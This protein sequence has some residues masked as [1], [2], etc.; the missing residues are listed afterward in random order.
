MADN[1][2]DIDISLDDIMGDTT[3]FPTPDKSNNP[4]NKGGQDNNDP[5]PDDDNNDDSKF[6]DINKDSPEVKTKDLFV[7][8]AKE[9]DLSDDNKA[10]KSQLLSKYK[11]TSFNQHGDIIDENNEIVKKFDEVYKDI[12]KEDE[13]KLDDKG[14]Q[15]DDD[16]NIIKS[17]EELDADKSAVNKIHQNLEYEFKDEAGNVKTYED[18]DEGLLE[19]ASDI[20]NA[21]AQEIQTRFINQNP[22]LAE[23]AKH[24]LSGKDLDSYK[25]E[26][27]YSKVDKE[28]LSKDAKIKYIRDSYKVKGFSDER[29]DA[30]IRRI[31][32]GNQVDEELDFALEDLDKYQESNKAQRQ[33]DYDAAVQK[34]QQELE[35]YWDDVKNTVDKGE[36]R[37]L[38]IPKEEKAKF[39]DYMTKPVKNGL[40][41]A[42]I[43]REK[44]TTQDLLTL[45]FL[46][47]KGYK[48]DTLVKGKA[49]TA[50]VKGLKNLIARSA[51]I[52]AE[53]FSSSGKSKGDNTTPDVISIDQIT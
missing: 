2:D 19:L 45:E 15:V 9:E 25:Q 44:E 37:E 51:K 8:L 35:Q 41:Q 5:K 36:L 34:E 32:D 50:R 11:G 47:Y 39:F 14:N 4:D 26:I 43:D 12:L 46:R 27:D 48:L 29:I 20:A 23:V 21:K 7:S 28:K 16:G 6:V 33:A 1:N 31:E 42:Q 3:S 30:N 22:V 49:N 24:L 10:L 13:I 52:K 18:S 38:T 53:D 17:K 40:S